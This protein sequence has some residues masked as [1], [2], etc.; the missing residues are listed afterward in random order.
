[1]DD[2]EK[3]KSII[4]NVKLYLLDAQR[5]ENGERSL[6]IM[7]ALAEIDGIGELREMD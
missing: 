7:K 1:M 3:M 2:L 6:F 5:A 4:T